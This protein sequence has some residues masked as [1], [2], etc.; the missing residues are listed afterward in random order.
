MTR[1]MESIKTIEA[2]YNA[3]ENEEKVIMYFYTKWCPDCFVIK[4]HLG[5]LEDDFKSY[6]FYRF[7]RDK[8]IEL[9]KEQGVKVG[10]I[11]PITLFPFPTKIIAE[12]AIRSVIK[13]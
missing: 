9:A 2:F 12:F 10:L 7:D 13:N 1:Q 6:K 4:R 5:K 11:R 3:I 8:S